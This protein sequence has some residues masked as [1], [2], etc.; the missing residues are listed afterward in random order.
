MEEDF[1]TYLLDPKITVD[2]NLNLRECREY[3]RVQREFGLNNINIF[4][5][6]EMLRLRAKLNE[7]GFKT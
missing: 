2:F 3:A 7:K 4:E 1:V 6:K 5:F